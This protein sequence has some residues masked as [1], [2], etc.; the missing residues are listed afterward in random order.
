[1][2]K[3][4]KKKLEH[5]RTRQQ[6]LQQQ[7]AGMR[8]QNDS[9]RELASLEKQVAEISAEIEKLKSGNSPGR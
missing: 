5:L 6:K 9:P 4:A 2:D 1:M 3:K 8:R 7:L